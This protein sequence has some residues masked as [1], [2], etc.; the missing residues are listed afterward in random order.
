MTSPPPTRAN[1]RRDLPAGTG[2]LARLHLWAGDALIRG[3]ALFR[4]ALSLGVRLVAFAPDGRVFLVR[5]SYLPGWHLPGGA[6]EPGE[7]ARQAAVRE[8]RE[9]G[10]LELP[11]PLRLLNVYRHDTT[12]RRDQEV[13]F[14]AE[15]ATRDAAA[16]T[17][18]EIREAGFFDPAAPPEGAT[19][20]TLDR[21]AE[22]A[23]RVP[24]VDTW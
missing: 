9:E 12:G 13:V 16:R 22:A 24:I 5:H 2:R 4:P 7:T 1:R 17:G 11:G 20:A 6:V 19:R 8:A 10:G 15:G 23:G 21:V 14:V 3:A 18:L